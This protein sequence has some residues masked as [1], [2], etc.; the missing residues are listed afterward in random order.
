MNRLAVGYL[1]LLT[2][3]LAFGPS[4]ADPAAP[5]DGNAFRLLAGSITVPSDWDGIWTTQDSVYDCTTGP[6]STS[7]SVDTICSGQSFNGGSSGGSPFTCTG[8]ADATTIH[9]T[10]TGSSAAGT[11]CQADYNIQMDVTRTNTTY[12]SVSTINVTYSGTGLGCDLYPPMC[13]RVVSYGTRTGPAPTAYCNTAVMRPT[14]GR[15]K[16]LYR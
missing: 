8:T 2:T 12:K 6:M 11:D 3:L 4:H 1:L 16:T 7:S 15:L 14:W 9:A 13:L 10:C 5:R